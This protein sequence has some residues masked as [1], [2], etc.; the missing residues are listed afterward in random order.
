MFSFYRSTITEDTKL[1][2]FAAARKSNT[3]YVM[4]TIKEKNI[5]VSDWS[6]IDDYEQTLLHI[7]VKTKN[8]TLAQELMDMKMS[9]IKKNMFEE[10]PMDI[11]LRNNDIKMIILLSGNENA[12]FLKAENG[13]LLGT[14][15]DQKELIV[16]MTN[17]NTEVTKKNSLLHMELDTE[18]KSLKRKRNEYETVLNDNIRLVSENKR[19]KVDNETL[20]KTIGTLSNSMR[21]NK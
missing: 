5:N 10:T 16:S 2:L 6:L 13:R 11:A 7:A 1:S 21:K 19:L 8:Y 15:N 3:T 17:I 4:K 9:P 14:I 20:Q 18:R 12:A